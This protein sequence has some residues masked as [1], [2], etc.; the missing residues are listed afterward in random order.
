MDISIESNSHAATIRPRVT[1]HKLMMPGL[2]AQPPRPSQRSAS[3]LIRFDEN[4]QRSLNQPMVT[5]TKPPA[6]RPNSAR[7]LEHIT[8]VFEQQ[9]LQ[10]SRGSQDVPK[11]TTSLGPRRP[12]DLITEPKREPIQSKTT[13]S[14]REQ[15]YNKI[16]AELQSSLTQLNKLIDETG[17]PGINEKPPIF[18]G[19][20]RSIAQR[21]E[22]FCKESNSKKPIERLSGWDPEND[23]KEKTSSVTDLRSVFEINTDSLR[24]SSALGHRIGTK[25]P[26]PLSNSNQ[27]NTTKTYGDFAIRRT[28]STSS[29]KTCTVRNPYRTHYGLR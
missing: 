14:D 6:H 5:P 19:E 3:P 13:I 26:M 2:E 28:V 22:S 4:A 21:R 17:T 20:I 7:P 29:P 18:S 15:R 12:L 23:L 8:N 11:R 9:I 27:T 24:S 25:P 10:A 1:V 16:T